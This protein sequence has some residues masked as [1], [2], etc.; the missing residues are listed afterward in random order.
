M[1]TLRASSLPHACLVSPGLPARR[2]MPAPTPL[3]TLARPGLA[4]R[5]AT[6]FAA[7]RRDEPA[8]PPR[9]SAQVLVLRRA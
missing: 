1:T 8:L 5:M 6:W 3:P 9:R 7:A 4:E 2:R